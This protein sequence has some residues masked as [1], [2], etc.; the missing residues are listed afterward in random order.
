MEAVMGPEGGGGW[1]WQEDTALEDMALDDPD[2]PMQV[3]SKIKMAKVTDNLWQ[4]EDIEPEEIPEGLKN[5][6]KQ[7]G[8][9]M[10]ALRSV[11]KNIGKDRQAWQ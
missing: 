5:E 1:F 7:S 2:D 9:V 8:A 11:R 10:V 4:K 6:I 3:V